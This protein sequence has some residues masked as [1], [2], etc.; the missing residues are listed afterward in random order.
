MFVAGVGSWA[1]ETR[2]ERVALCCEELLRGFSFGE[3]FYR[4]EVDSR[5]YTLEDDPIDPENH[6]LVEE[7][8]RSQGASQDP[9]LC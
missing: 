3:G 6:W 4:R 1:R 5:Q 9:G 7:N 2:L 8:R